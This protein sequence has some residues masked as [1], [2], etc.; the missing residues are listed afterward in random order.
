MVL[1]RL[2]PLAGLTLAIVT[3]LGALCLRLRN[4]GSLGVYCIVLFAVIVGSSVLA[5]RY[6][7]TK[8]GS[9]Y[10]IEV[11]SMFAVSIAH[12]F[13]FFTV[14]ALMRAIRVQMLLESSLSDFE[15]SDLELQ[16]EEEDASPASAPPTYAAAAAAAANAAAA[17]SP[18]PIFVAAP[19][20]Y[21]QFNGQPFMP[22]AYPSPVP[23]FVPIFV[24]AAGKPISPVR[25]Q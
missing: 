1:W 20:Y 9:A 15:L 16:Q 23:Q 14:I 17:P 12:T 3:V 11:A 8:P 24:D 21:P 25:T 2:L 18:S 10:L 5:C 22:Q 13:T 4:R 7:Y 6:I 19:A